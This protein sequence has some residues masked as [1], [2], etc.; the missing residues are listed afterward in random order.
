MRLLYWIL[1][2]VSIAVATTIGVTL[3]YFSASKVINVTDRIGWKF[4]ETETDIIVVVGDDGGVGI[5]LNSRNFVFIM[6]NGK[7]LEVSKKEFLQ[8]EVGDYFTYQERVWK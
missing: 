7:E 3:W 8:Y 4:V 6:E 1:M 5:P 2:I